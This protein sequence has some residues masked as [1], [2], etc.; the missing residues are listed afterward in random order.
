MVDR[1]VIVDF[2]DHLE[3]MQGGDVIIISRRP[4]GKWTVVTIS[5]DGYSVTGH[6]LSFKEA[7]EN[8]AE[9]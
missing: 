7:W 9:Q 6:G 5:G 2:E 8:E 3:G 4:G 1:Q